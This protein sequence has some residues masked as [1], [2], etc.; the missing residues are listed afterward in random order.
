MR[1]VVPRRDRRALDELL[2]R[3]P[4]VRTKRTQRGDQLRLGAHEPRSV[5][6][7][8]RALRQRLKDDNVPTVGELHCRRRRRV[9][10][11]L[12]VRLV[13]GEIETVRAGE[14]CRL[15]EKRQRRHRARRVVR[16][17]EPQNRATLPRLVIDRSRS[18]SQPCA[19]SSRRNSTRAPANIAPRSYTGYAGSGTST[20][21]LS[22][23][24]ATSGKRRSPPS[25]RQVG[26]SSRLRI[27]IRAETPCKQRRDRLAQLRQPARV[28]SPPSGKRVRQRA[29]DE[30]GCSARSGRPCRSRSARCR[31]RARPP[32]PRRDARTDT[33]PAPRAPTHTS[34]RTGR[35]ALVRPCKLSDL[36]PLV[37]RVREARRTRPEVHGVEALRRNSATGVHACFGSSSKSPA[38][39]SDC[40]SGDAAATRA[41]GEFPS[42]SSS[43]FPSTSSRRRFSA[44]AG[45]RSGA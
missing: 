10:P 8:R 25:S 45:V 20:T 16:V 36:D 3:R 31:A 21:S 41:G 33:S 17:V 9:E 34:L 39:R 26:T 18:G 40:T 37:L 29:L 6:G 1:L 24:H 15:L 4:S 32:S 7:H 13:A 43:P 2:R 11:Q 22:T 42:S 27:D 38:W 35:S 5:A 23:V 14:L 12:G 30:L 19:S 28:D 44:S